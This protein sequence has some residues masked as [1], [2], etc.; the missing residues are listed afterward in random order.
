MTK[1]TQ[2]ISGLTVQVRKD[3]YLGLWNLYYE[4][5]SKYAGPYKTRKEAAERL[6]EFSEGEAV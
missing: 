6:R 4:R 5:G 2:K 1:R 3:F